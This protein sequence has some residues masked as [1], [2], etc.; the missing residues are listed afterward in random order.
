MLLLVLLSLIFTPTSFRSDWASN[1]GAAT[2]ADD[3]IEQKK[4]LFNEVCKILL[5]E[6]LFG[7]NFL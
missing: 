1:I 4:I 3:P 2:N 6:K 7:S 5:A